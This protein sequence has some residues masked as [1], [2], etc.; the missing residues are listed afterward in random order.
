MPFKL[1]WTIKQVSVH[2]I[3]N[4]I[5]LWNKSLLRC[6]VYMIYSLSVIVFLRFF[7]HFTDTSTFKIFLDCMS[8]GFMM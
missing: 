7:P 2:K 6:L 3:N 8:F 5:K 1:F 4:A